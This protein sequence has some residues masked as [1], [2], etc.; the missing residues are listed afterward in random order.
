MALADDVLG[1]DA[2]KFFADIAAAGPKG[3]RVKA[4]W[5]VARP[6]GDFDLRLDTVVDTADADKPTITRKAADVDLP[7]KS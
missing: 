1:F 3:L 2:D 5:L 6:D 4:G 7:K